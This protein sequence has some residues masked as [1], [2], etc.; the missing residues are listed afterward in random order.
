MQIG[1]GLQIGYQA[2]HGGA[3]GAFDYLV[4]DAYT[5]NLTAGNVDG[6][7]AE[8]GPGVR[9]IDDSQDQ[10]TIA[11]SALAFAGT[12]TPNTFGDP[13]IWYGPFGRSVGLIMRVDVTPAATNKLFM[14][15][16]GN[17]NTA[18]N[19]VAALRFRGAGDVTPDQAGVGPSLFSYAATTYQIA[20]ILR[21]SGYLAFIKGG[22]FT[23]WTLLYIYAGN[24]TQPMFASVQSNSAQLTVDNLIVPAARWLP[25]PLISDGFGAWGSSDGLGHAEGVADSIGNGGSGVSWSDNGDWSASG[26][27]AGTTPTAG[28]DLVTDGG[29]ENWDTATDL[30]SW[31]EQ[32][33]GSSTVN[34]ETSVVHAGSNAARFTIDGSNSLAKINQSITNS[35][36]DWLL[37]TLWAKT[38][39]SGRSIAVDENNGSNV[40]QTLKLST[41]YEPYASLIRATKANTDIGVKRSVGTSA[42]LYID[43]ISAQVIDLDTMIAGADL[44]ENDVLAD[45]NITADAGTLAGLLICADSI[46]TLANGILVLLD[47]SGLVHVCKLVAGTLTLVTSET[48]TYS[49]GATLRAIKS[50]SAMRVFYNDAAVGSELT[51]SDAGIVSNTIHGLIASD[52]GSTFD[53]LVVYARGTDGEYNSV[54]DAI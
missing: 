51:I 41:T 45:V 44:S 52:A 50:G 10:I 53:D 31:T 9:D 22:A 7:D 15:G 4:N 28:S 34:Q 14:V 27:L 20:L 21:V 37:V 54:L 19:N 40:G 2:G 48:V 29:L 36:G 47:P 8:P 6:T 5:S 33:G 46:S 39:V 49:A 32:V 26:G 35:N 42:N 43:D 24:A 11:S 25:T 1:I 12:K 30:T 17:N 23:N 13:A 3:V 38:D 16:W 18:I